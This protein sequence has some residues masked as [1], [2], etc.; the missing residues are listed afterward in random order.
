MNKYKEGI[1]F[2][3]SEDKKYIIVDSMNKGENEYLLSSPIN[4]EGS[5]GKIDFSKM[6][7]VKVD[8]KT[9]EMKIETDDKIIE[10]VI[11]NSLNKIKTQ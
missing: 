7:L 4:Y 2:E 10:E 11:R 3:L 6:L 9:N 5:K 1:V 8:N